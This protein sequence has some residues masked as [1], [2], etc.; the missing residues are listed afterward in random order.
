[1]KNGFPRQNWGSFEYICEIRPGFSSYPYPEFGIFAG[2]DPSIDVGCS[3]NSL[4][5]LPQ[6]YQE[7]EVGN[8]AE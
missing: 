2:L 8:E 7:N 4:K 1:M 3:A 6:S 5:I